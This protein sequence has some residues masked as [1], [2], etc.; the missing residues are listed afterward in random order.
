[1]TYSSSGFGG[2]LTAAELKTIEVIARAE[3][4]RALKGLRIVL[5]PTGRAVSGPSRAAAP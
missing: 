3:I 1:M 4:T 2:P 5:G